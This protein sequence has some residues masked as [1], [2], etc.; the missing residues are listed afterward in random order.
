MCDDTR[1]CKDGC[2]PRREPYPTALTIVAAAWMAVMAAFIIVWVVAALWQLFAFSALWFGAMTIPVL[3]I[4]WQI[5]RR[6]RA[7]RER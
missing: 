1:T 7:R 6:T 3:L 5:A 4:G 2:C